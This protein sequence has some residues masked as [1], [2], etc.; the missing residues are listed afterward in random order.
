M[1]CDCSLRGVKMRERRGHIFLPPHSNR[2]PAGKVAHDTFKFVIITCGRQLFTHRSELSTWSM[3]ITLFTVAGLST[4]GFW[5]EKKHVIAAILSIEDC[6]AICFLWKLLFQHLR[7]LILPFCPPLHIYFLFLP[8]GLR[9]LHWISPWGSMWL[10]QYS[11]SDLLQPL[12]LSCRGALIHS[13]LLAFISV[14]GLAAVIL[15]MRRISCQRCSKT[16]ISF[17]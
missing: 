12:T 11:Y 2:G 8:S 10:I 7:L 15:D 5:H 13:C 17:Y 14:S 6:D 4:A 3:N 1:E 16:E 9:K